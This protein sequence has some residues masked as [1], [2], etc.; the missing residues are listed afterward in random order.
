M[1]KVINPKELYRAMRDAMMS[2][3]ITG[4]LIIC[5]DDYDVITDIEVK[6]EVIN[7]CRS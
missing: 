7:V 3:M 6:G 4:N 2:Q 1:S 5:V